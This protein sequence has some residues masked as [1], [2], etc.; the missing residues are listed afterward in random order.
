MRYC[1]MMLNQDFF[2]HAMIY[3]EVTQ[4]LQ[5]WHNSCIKIYSEIKL[6]SLEGHGRKRSIQGYYQYH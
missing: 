1:V 4:E 3:I 5:T 2:M 6:S